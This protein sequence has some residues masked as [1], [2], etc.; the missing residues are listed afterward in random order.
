MQ[1]ASSTGTKINGVPV[2]VTR[3]DV[4]ADNWSFS[5]RPLR[6][7][8]G[9]AVGELSSVVRE[10]K[11]NLHSGVSRRRTFSPVML[12]ASI[13]WLEH[14]SNRTGWGTAEAYW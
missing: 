7:P 10:R 4:G 12:G 6:G 11:R 5:A 1:T 13:R 2:L 9:T 8:S 3:Q 14:P